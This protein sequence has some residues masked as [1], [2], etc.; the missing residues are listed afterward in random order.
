MRSCRAA[1]DT[2]VSLGAEK[3]EVTVMDGIF[4]FCRLAHTMIILSEMRSAIHSFL[5]CGE[6]RSK[7]G[8]DS[9]LTLC[10]SKPLTASDYMQASCLRTLA[11]QSMKE[12]FSSVDLIITPATATTAP[13]INTPDGKEEIDVRMEALLMRYVF[14]GNFV[15]IP[16]LTMPC[17]YTPEGLPIGVQLLGRWWEEHVVLK[18]AFAL[19]SRIT[20]REPA[21]SFSNLPNGN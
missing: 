6:T 12:A 4:E 5:D 11:I 8:L 7:F 14:V 3:V 17:G 13:R 9:Q 19:E 1:V 18:A 15:G 10:V 2:L 21:V 20:K 16:A